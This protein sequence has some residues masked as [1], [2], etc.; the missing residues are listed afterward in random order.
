MAKDLD[1][2]TC[3]PAGRPAGLHTVHESSFEEKQAG[4]DSVSL[5]R[6]GCFIT[7]YPRV[8]GSRGITSGLVQY[9]QTFL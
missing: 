3:L 7:L 5:Q 8:A 4:S 9:V 2:G 6:V 1:G